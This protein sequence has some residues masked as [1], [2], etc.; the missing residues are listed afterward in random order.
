MNMT[1]RKGFTLLELLMVVIIIAILAALAIPQY[2]KTAERARMSEAM[3]MLGQ[4]R[5][6][7]IR[8]RAEKE[9]FTA[10]L[11]NLDLNPTDI[12]GTSFFTYA[13]SAANANTFIATAKRN[14]QLP[15]GSGCINGYTVSINEQGAI[16]GQDCQT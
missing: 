9:T 4:I 12:L 1:Q 2:I 14:G 8:Y 15:T 5:S 3:S 13:V 6:S 7:E 11:T 10:T 16:T